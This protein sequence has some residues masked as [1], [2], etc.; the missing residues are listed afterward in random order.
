MRG[1]ELESAVWDDVEIF[2][3]KPGAILRQ[4][5]AQVAANGGKG[6]RVKDDILQLE[7]AVAQTGVARKMALRQLTR[8]IIKEAEFDEEIKSIDREATV[9]EERLAGLRKASAEQDA[10]TLAVG[11]ARSLL[12]ELQAKTCGELTFGKRRR[13]VEALV[14]DITVT[15]VEGQKQPKI[16]ITFRFDPHYASALAKTDPHAL[17]KSGPGILT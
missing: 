16:K 5:E 7:A 8:G 11:E 15:R 4:L 13:A 6:R 1:A 14:Q 17:S 12:E 3:A 10:T 2:L 9:V